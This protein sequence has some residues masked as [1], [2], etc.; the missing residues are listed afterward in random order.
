M[1][2]ESK[3]NILVVDDTETNIDILAN[4]LD[5]EYDVSVAMD[6]ESA[7]DIAHSA[8]PDLIL[9]DIMM[10]GM[11]GFEVC[12]R[13]KESADTAEIP[14]LFLTAMTE[15]QN[16]TK[17]FEIGAVDY[18]TKPFEI[19]EVEAR[20][21]THLKLKEAKDFLANQNEILEKK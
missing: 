9:L 20:V 6:G 19:R 4:A 14:V 7:L 8:P 13:L 16:K 17:G 18:I 15:M 11:D 21:R 2:T 3:Y 1:K 12:E 5:T 10:P